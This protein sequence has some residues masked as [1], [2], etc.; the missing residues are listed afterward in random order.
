MQRDGLTRVTRRVA[1]FS[2]VAAHAA[3]GNAAKAARIDCQS[4]LFSE[5]FLKL[6]ARRRTSPYVV[7]EGRDRYVIVGEWRRRI[8]PKHTDLPSKLADMDRTGIEMAALSINDPG[9]E[10]F[11]NDSGAMAVM[12]NDFIAEAVKQHPKRFFGLATLPFHSPDAMLREFDRAV[13]KLGMKGVLLYSN[14]DGRYP[15]EEPFRPLFAEAERLGIPLL[16]HPACPVTFQQTRAYEMV[17]MLGL[18]FDTT[19][20]LTRLIL[21]GVLEKHPNLKLVCPHVGG[22]LPYLVGRL[23]HQT[24]VLKRG[25]DHITRPPSEYLKRVWLDTVNPIGLAIKYARDFVGPD[26][27]LYSSD[28]PWVDPQLII[29]QVEAQQFPA[30]D[31]SK[32]WSGN[33]RALFRL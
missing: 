29:D 12:L 33:A 7:T 21:S 8:L 31:L 19:I 27:L 11:G 16:L 17:A 5:E 10:L 32:L 3:K 22:A 20:A 25:A 26:R 13:N 14:L 2:P 4:H 15:D 28:H 1:M 23:D 30:H 18:M 9:P 24:M 6:L